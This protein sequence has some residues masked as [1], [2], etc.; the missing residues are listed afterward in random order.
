MSNYHGCK[1]EVTNLIKHY[2]I[3]IIYK[4]VK[5]SHLEKKFSSHLR[6]FWLNF[7]RANHSF[8]H[9]FRLR[10]NRLS[11][12]FTWSFEWVN[13]AWV[14]MHRFNAYSRNI[15]IINWKIFPHMLE[16]TSQKKIHL[17]FWRDTALRSLKKYEIMYLW[18]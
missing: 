18:R 12:N 14:K 11:K 4:I 7:D 6:V 17:G 3:D 1:E 16:Y 2:L 8:L 15:N 10:G 9:H 5:P 13:G